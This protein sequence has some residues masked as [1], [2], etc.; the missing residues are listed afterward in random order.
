MGPQAF[1]EEKESGWVSTVSAEVL[2]LALYG[3]VQPW[4]QK[5]EKY[6]WPMGCQ[7][8]SHPV[9]FIQSGPSQGK[10]LGYFLVLI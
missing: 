2:N 1:K 8:N 9:K 4:V 7:R 5:E 3:A 6:D 10:I